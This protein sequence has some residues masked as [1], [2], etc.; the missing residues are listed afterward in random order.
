M[1]IIIQLGIIFALG[2]IGEVAASL[3]PFTLPSSVIGLVLL[4]ILLR[5][6]LL[7]LEQIGGVAGFLPANMGFFFVPSAVGIL[8]NYDIMRPV[9]WKLVFICFAGATLTFLTTYATV[10]LVRSLQQKRGAVK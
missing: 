10:R 8:Q 2:F 3:L 6:G 1:Q 9:L 5:T 4:L 7:K